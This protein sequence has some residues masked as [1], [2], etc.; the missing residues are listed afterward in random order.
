MNKYKPLQCVINLEMS[1][2]SLEANKW[3]Y[4]FKIKGSQ[5]QALWDTTCQIKT[6]LF[7]RG[8]LFIVIQNVKYGLNRNYWWQTQTDREFRNF[9]QHVP[10][11][12]LKFMEDA[13]R[14]NI[15]RNG[16]TKCCDYSSDHTIGPPVMVHLHLDGKSG[17]RLFGLVAQTEEQRSNIWP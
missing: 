10:R 9:R 3:S 13:S 17:T 6:S 16:R 11:A 8:K 15:S 12:S 2:I 14:Q 5:T 1:L 7:S 4:Q